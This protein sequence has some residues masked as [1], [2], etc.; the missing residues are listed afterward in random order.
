V[1]PKKDAGTE[2]VPVLETACASQV[3]EVH[4]VIRQN[5]NCVLRGIVLSQG[6]AAVGLD[7]LG[8]G[9]TSVWPI[10]AA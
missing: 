5:A 6:S 8:R 2:L 1:Q 3:G 4:S 10:L 9:V 7:G